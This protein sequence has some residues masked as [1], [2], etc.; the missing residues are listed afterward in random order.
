MDSGVENQK[1]F[2]VPGQRLCC[3]DENTVAGH[4]T[5]ERGDG[6]IYTVL[7]GQVNIWKE[8]STTFIEVKPLGMETIV[9]T[10]GDVV[11]AKIT[12]VN[13]RFAKCLIFSV[14]H[15]ILNRSYRGVLKKEDIR[16]AERDSVEVQK[17]FRPGDVILAR[18]MPQT[19]LHHYQLTTAE[20]ELG[21]AMA[22]SKNDSTGVVPMVP[23]SWDEM[24]CPETLMKE[25]RKVARVVSTNY[26]LPDLP[27]KD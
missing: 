1:I 26:C 4:G 20:N 7:T 2:C 27:R 17:C 10:V 25:P 24:Q 3:A 12:V 15:K 9:P 13:Q 5:Y 8:K 14:G 22:I 18:V 16:A 21:V 19:E 11:T 6:Y 23:I